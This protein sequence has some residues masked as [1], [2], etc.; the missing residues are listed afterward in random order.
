MLYSLYLE[1]SKERCSPFPNFPLCFH[2]WGSFHFV[3][4]VR[5]PKKRCDYFWPV[6]WPENAFSPFSYAGGLL[7]CENEKLNCFDIQCVVEASSFSLN[8]NMALES[9]EN[10]PRHTKTVQ[11]SLGFMREVKP[12]HKPR[13]DLVLCALWRL[14]K[15]VRISFFLILWK[16]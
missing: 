7:V 8:H 3:F 9:K 5:A 1:A 15:V 10:Y 16:I 4:A 14:L 11:N 6:F 13:G 12:L 2:V